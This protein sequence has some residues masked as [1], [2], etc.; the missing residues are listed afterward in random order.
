MRLQC[1]VVIGFLLS[2]SAAFGD[3]CY[4]PE[5]AV[6]KIPEI[7][8]QRALLSWKD[9]VETLVI[10]SALNSEAQTLGWIIPVPAVPTTVEK[11]T[12]GSLKTWNPRGFDYRSGTRQAETTQTPTVGNGFLEGRIRVSAARRHRAGES[13]DRAGSQYRESHQPLDGSDDLARIEGDQP[14]PTVR[15]PESDPTSCRLYGSVA[16]HWRRNE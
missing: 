6:R 12:P 8:A 5:R 1:L 4:V 3:G 16:R 14:R 13:R 2:A 9:G 10:S 15:E 11:A 7:A